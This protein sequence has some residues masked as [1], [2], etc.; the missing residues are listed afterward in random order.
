[1]CD[2]D[3][4]SEA[5]KAAADPHRNGDGW[6]CCNCGELIGQLADEVERLKKLLEEPEP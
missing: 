6:Y 1:M 5:R 2:C 4:L 3:L